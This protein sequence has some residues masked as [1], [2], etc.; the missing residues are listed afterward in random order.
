M[1]L[2]R[3][4]PACL[5]LMLLPA[6]PAAAADGFMSLQDFQFAPAVV[7]IERGEKVDFNFEGPSAHNVVIGH[8][9]T[10]RWGNRSA[11]VQN[12]FRVR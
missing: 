7:Q 6:G 11:P 2:A 4:V 12:S 9:Q 1:R 8:G 5:A 10:D 3:S